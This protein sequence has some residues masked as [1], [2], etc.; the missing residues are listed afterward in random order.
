MPTHEGRPLVDAYAHVGLPR[1][2]HID[3]YRFVM[4]ADGIDQAVLCLFDSCPDV[5]GVHA[6][7]HRWPDTFRVLGVPLGADD[8]EREAGIEAQLDAGFSGIRFADSDVLERPW[9]LD[10]VAA[11]GRV[12][13]VCGRP[14]APEIA[15]ELLAV[16]ERHPGA[17]LVGGH[18]AGA[19]D[20]RVLTEPGPVADLFAQPRFSVVF[21]R[22]GG[23]P[24]G[25]IGDWARALVATCGWERLLW[26]SEAPVLFWR[27][28]TVTTALSWV[29]QLEPTAEERAAFFG[30]N[31]RRLYFGEPVHPADLRMPFDVWERARPIPAGVWASGLPVEQSI[32]GRLVQSWLRSGG[33][34]TLG[35]YAQTVLD[36]A[37]PALEK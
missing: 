22:H 8:K 9:L 32:A 15:R 11:R 34:G 20:P 12:G 16:L 23:Y 17:H 25:V 31:T 35:E 28:E 19:A 29:D 18:F 24:A 36:Q 26:G 21:S 30:G 1:F 10:L 37:L 33:Q 5:A 27:N 2:Q 14:S 13:I 3:D 4:A 7:V 6:A